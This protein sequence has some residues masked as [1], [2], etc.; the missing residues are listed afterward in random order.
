[1]KQYERIVNEAIVAGYNPGRNF[2]D[3]LVDYYEDKL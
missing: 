2:F 1:M 3:F